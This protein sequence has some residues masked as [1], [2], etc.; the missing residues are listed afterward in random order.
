MKVMLWEQKFVLR[1][2]FS[3]QEYYFFADF[4]NVL[5]SMFKMEADQLAEVDIRFQ[6]ARFYYTM[7]E[8]INHAE[9]KVCHNTVQLVL[10]NGKFVIIILFQFYCASQRVCITPLCPSIRFSCLGHNS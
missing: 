1:K 9:N 3:F 2:R 5:N 8:M 6:I 10:F 4:P 7:N